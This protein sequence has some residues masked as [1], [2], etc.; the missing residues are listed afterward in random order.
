MSDDRVY[1]VS[2]L[3]K[4]AGVS[5]RTLH[6]YDQIGLLKT[7]RRKDNGFREYHN[8]HVMILQQILLYRELDFSIETIREILACDDYD[9]LKAFDDQKLMLRERIDK[10]QLMINSIEETMS[11]F[12][13]KLNREIM[14]DDIPK[15][16]IERWDQIRQDQGQKTVSET[17]LQNSEKL[18]ETEAEYLSEESQRW[19]N[20][21]SK[22][23][24]LPIES[25]EVQ[26]C[27]LQHYK[28]ANRALYTTH[29]GFEGIGYHGYTMFASQIL[30]DK[31][32][33]ELHEHYGQG[34]AEHLNKA[35]LFFAENTLKDNLAELRKLGLDDK[36]K[37]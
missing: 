4:F 9:L 1:T 19:C 25:E 13:G 11:N 29:E 6:Y 14:F 8:R 23:L 22:L 27:V 15:E 2:E 21:Y 26:E 12:R 31:V 7:V 24:D 16:K 37:H 5:I 3:S 30:D 28:I 34:L 33:Y 20:E 32:T 35:M 17:M 18:S 10:A 36:P